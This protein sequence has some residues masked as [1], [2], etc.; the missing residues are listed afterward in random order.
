MPRSIEDRD[1]FKQRLANEGSFFIQ[2][3]GKNKE[4]QVSGCFAKFSALC[5]ISFVSHD[6]KMLALEF[7]L[8]PHSI[9]F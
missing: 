5:M 1:A 4:A 7:I 6:I 8:Q 2:T 9:I 3:C